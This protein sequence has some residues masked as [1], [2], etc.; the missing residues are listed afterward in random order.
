VYNILWQTTIPLSKSGVKADSMKI[1]IGGGTGFIGNVLTEKLIRQGHEV[2][3]L[4]RAIEKDRTLPKN[5]KV[6][7]CDTTKPGNWQT[8]VAQHDAVINLAG[9]SIFRRWTPPGKHEI[10]DSR[11]LSTKKHR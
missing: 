5:I 11:I 8:A 6:I 9:A 1:L 10:L 4:A 2:T 7:P 3:V